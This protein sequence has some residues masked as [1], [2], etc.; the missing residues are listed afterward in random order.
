M[1]SPAGLVVPVDLIGFCVSEADEQEA[2]GS[3]AG[4]TV[5]Y[6]DQT[7]SQTPAY[8]G[9]NVARGFDAAPWKRLEAGVHLH[10]ALPDAL[11]KASVNETQTAVQFPAAPNRWLITRFVMNGSTPTATSWV[12]ESDALNNVAP[13]GQ[14]PVTVPIQA[15]TSNSQDFAYLGQTTPLQSYAPAALLEG[16]RTF[17]NATGFELSAVSNGVPTFASFYP[18]SRSAFGFVDPLSDLQVPAN[19]M[20]VV[21][22]WFDSTTNDPSSLS[23][24]L[25]STH[26]WETGAPPAYTLYSGLVQDIA[27]DP[28]RNY[29][30]NQPNQQPIT[31]QAAVGNTPIEALSAYFRALN[32]PDVPFFEQLLNAFQEGLLPKLKTPSPGLLAK[33]AEALHDN[34]FQAVDSGLIYTIVLENP[35][36]TE[37]EATDLSPP[38]AYALNELNVAAL[39]LEE[40][41]TNV[42]SFQWRMFADWYRYF[43]AD[44]S[45]N[46]AVF[47][48]AAGLYAQWTDPNTGLQ[49]QLTQAQAAVQTQL[50]GLN[51]MLKNTPLSLKA[52]PAPRYWQPTDPAVLLASP[53]LSFPLRYGGDTQFSPNGLLFCRGT[54]QLVS[55][56]T[57]GGTSISGST[58]AAVCALPSSTLPYATDC[59]NLLI[60]ACLMNTQIAAS[61]SGQTDAA[62][63]TALQALLASQPQT[64]WTIVTGL[65]PSPVELA[66][67]GPQNPWMPLFL[68][69][70]VNFAPLQPT[71]TGATL[72]DY[73]TEFFT[74]NFTVDTETGSFVSYTPSTG[75]GGITV[76]PGSIPFP[77]SWT[78]QSILSTTSAAN[79][80]SAITSALA[81][82][83]DPTLQTILDE[84]NATPT[85][86]QAMSGFTSGLTMQQD[87][88]QLQIA[89]PASAAFPAQTITT[90]TQGVV[91]QYYHVGPQ[92]GWS[93]NPIRAGWFTITI[94]AVDVFGQ[95]RDVTL[96]SI[97]EAESMTAYSQQKP[98]ANVSYAAPR[99]AQPSRLLF[100]WISAGAGG[101]VEMNNH[102]A[103]TPVCGWLLPNHLD[104]G[105]F[106]YDGVGK[107]LGSLQLNGN[108]TQVVWMSAPGDDATID[109]PIA[110]A[111]ADVNPTFQALALALFAASPAWFLDFWKAVDTVHGGISPQTLA[112]NAGLAVLIGRPVAVAQ[113][114]LR[115]DLRG[116]PALNQSWD[117]LS[118]SEWLDTE[119]GFSSV[120]FPVELGDFDNLD[121]GLIGFF[122]PGQ[123]GYEL[124]TFYTEGADPNAQSGV[125]QP[126]LDTILLTPSPKFDD[127]EPPPV[128]AETLPLLLL[129][130]PRAPVHATT[131]I[132]PTQTLQIPPDIAADAISI[133][134]MSFLV[135]PI[136]KPAGGLALPV[137]REP[138]Y[139]I[140]FVEQD[141]DGSNDP[142][143]VTFAD[144]A[145]PTSTAVWDYT[146]QT[147]DEGWLRLNPTVVTFD[148][149][150]SSGQA[151]V[152][153]GQTQSVTLTVANAKPADITFQ[154]GVIAP[155]G[156]AAKGSI[157]Y[158]HFGSLVAQ[159]DVA[160]MSFT[161]AGWSFQ[162]MNDATYGQY[163]AATPT[164]AVTLEPG[165]SFVIAIAGLKAVSD[166]VQ[167]Q[168]YTDY[169][170]VDGVAD[171][172]F[173]DLVT[174]TQPSS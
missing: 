63:Q 77:Q 157:F 8:L 140:S 46:G 126:G 86:V 161:A 81:K 116:R 89:V 124:S 38:M 91:G 174:I 56:V 15:G 31:A 55:Q 59:T 108:Q 158:V 20:Y 97:A 70:T 6:T 127:P 5:V 25:T 54:D 152:T 41:T 132:L 72:N 18:E 29:V 66:W 28:N 148:L 45:L 9:S 26:D 60:E 139:A 96:S 80:A 36:G 23:S 104:G 155:E 10:W 76:D 99:L 144:I 68:Q 83:P 160:A 44:P 143:W 32:H 69:W 159:A 48:H 79:L 22:G 105:F 82:Q 156:T 74:A 130:D 137:P 21:T 164:A 1:S 171:G 35:D 11:T 168:V 95:K 129:I 154:P 113:T 149:L 167:A 118:S 75:Q 90:E 47:N 13:A 12:I 2:T 128:A 135:A 87:I 19:L 43:Q 64:L 172:V 73:T 136:L 4:A 17:K 84:L 165:G 50:D 121:D 119:N 61:L 170:D 134:E 153:G 151:L 109:L 3:F 94:Q 30:L 100:D 24:D 85:L 14:S 147:L 52:G 133:L 166:A 57:A 125:V 120:Q 62:L 42:D 51:A 93:Y 40:L 88:L 58:F 7:G 162:A 27:W 110:Q 169:Y 173:A 78:G 49:V 101:L 53:D 163:W 111:L 115:L 146:P 150:N 141:L 16:A 39:A 122:L 98:V 114:A 117:C 67:W 138:G 34:Q 37:S 71:Q 107:P 102:P 112:T 92:F 145:A 103:S 65:A 33:L 131:G 142:E 123:T 106:L